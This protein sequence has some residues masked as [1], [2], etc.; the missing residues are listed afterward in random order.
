M[1]PICEAREHDSVSLYISAIGEAQNLPEPPATEVVNSAI[2]LFAISLP[3][4]A[5]KVQESILEQIATF[6]AANSLQRDPGRKAAMT[7]NI[8]LALLAAL[9]VSVKETRSAPGD[10]RSPPVEKIMQ[11]MLRVGKTS[12]SATRATSLTNDRGLWCI[13]INTSVILPMRR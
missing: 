5:P 7:V 13:L 11:E 9:K 2:N 4:Q 12:L 1:S 10:L 3:L 8:A 6:L